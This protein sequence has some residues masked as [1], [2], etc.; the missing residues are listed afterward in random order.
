VTQFSCEHFERAL[1][2]KHAL[3]TGGS[4][5]IGAAIVNLLL[6][7]GACVTS[8]SRSG[9]AGN[10]LRM[11]KTPGELAFVAADVTDPAAV[12]KAFEQARSRFG[13]VHILVNNAGQ[14]ASAPF[15]KTDLETWRSMM[16]VN[17]EGT[18]H[19]TQAALPNMLVARWGRIV[20][21]SSMAGL[22]GYAYVSAYCAAKH[23]VVGLTRA[24][25]MEVARQ[26]VT[27]NAVC[28]GYTETGMV[29]TSVANIVAKTG[30]SRDAALADLVARNPQKRLILPAE[31][32]NAVVWLCVP[33]SDAVTGQTIAVSGGETS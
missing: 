8:L 1:A 17:L 31:V 24:L 21:V 22:A 15:L 18:L 27:I 23:A 16:A 20:N 32:A 2:G 11:D 25:A 28:P 19:C 5:G 10:T 29:E 14:A 3:V 7:R 4:R 13:D 6:A 33:G 12:T 9:T 26:G 30:R